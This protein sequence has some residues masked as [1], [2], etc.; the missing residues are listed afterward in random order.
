MIP[1][2]LGNDVGSHRGDF[3]ATKLPDL[4]PP[5]LTDV[6]AEGLSIYRNE[7]VCHI[8]LLFCFLHFLLLTISGVM[9]F[10]TRLMYQNS[11]AGLVVIPIAIDMVFRYPNLNRVS[12]PPQRLFRFRQ[13]WLFAHRAIVT[14]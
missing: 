9:T 7:N 5:L 11:I 6:F 8:L 2:A 13:K 10:V 3:A 1:D 12:P 4:F 14:H